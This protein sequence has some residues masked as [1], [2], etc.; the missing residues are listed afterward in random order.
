M[1][2][3]AEGGVV[4]TV[5]GCWLEGGSSGSSDQ[6]YETIFHFLIGQVTDENSPG[7]VCGCVGGCVG[8]CGGE[9]SDLDL[10]DDLSDDTHDSTTDDDHGE[11]GGSG[12]SGGG[13]GG[14]GDYTSTHHPRYLSWR[15]S[16]GSGCEGGDSEGGLVVEPG[17][18]EESGAP[19]RTIRKVFTNTRERWRQQNVSGAFAELRRLVPTHPPDKKL[20]KNEILR[21]T[22]KYIKLL[23]SVLEWQQKHDNLDSD[24][25]NNNTSKTGNANSRSS[26]LR[27]MSPND[28]CLT[29]DASMRYRYL[30]LASPPSPNS[31]LPISS[32]S[33]TP[34]PV[35][36]STTSVR[37]SPL[38]TQVPTLPTSSPPSPTP[39]PT[40]STAP[41]P[42]PEELV[43]SSPDD[44]GRRYHPYVLA[45][46]VRP[47]L[48]LLNPHTN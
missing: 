9:S 11:D 39:A 34:S 37:P 12:G 38:P 27:P 43:P 18:G 41:S 28:T 29:L 10:A 31:P 4:Q 16:H 25:C 20:S 47:G 13:S 23:N 7:G 5:D 3:D 6:G 48:S 14:S 17:S 19:Q 21:L 36:Y 46:R 15:R 30:T 26:Q 24:S 44:P 40:P 45:L 2:V 42:A 35:S 32:T 22:I 1:E 8:G 33:S